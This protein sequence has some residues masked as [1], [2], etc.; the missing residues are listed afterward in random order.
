MND[1]ELTIRGF[2]GI[3]YCFVIKNPNSLIMYLSK[4]FIPTL[5][6]TP[7]D[8]EIASHRL[9]LRAGMIRRVGG[10]IFTFLPLGLRA[11]RHVE[12]IVREEMDRAGAIEVLMPG[13]QPRE[14]WEQ[15]GRY[16]AMRDVMFRMRDRQGH[17]LALGPTH[18]EV[19]T[20]LVA[21]EIHSYRQLPRTFYQVQ[22]KYRDEIRPRFGLMRAREF[23]MK[24]AYSFDTDWDAADGSYQAMYQAYERIFARCGL[25]VKVVEADSGAMGGQWSH[26]FMVPAE[27]GEDG[28]VECPQ[29]S[30]AAN[31]EKAE[32][33]R[34]AA[35][36]DGA[37]SAC[38]S[39]ENIAT[40]DTATI[41]AVSALLDIPAHRLIKTLIYS[42]DGRPVAVLTTGDREV[43]ELKLAHVLGCSEL[44]A[45]DAA[46][47]E[48]V[49]GAPVGY[50]GPIGLTIPI[51]ADLDLRGARDYVCGANQAGTHT[52]HIDM[53]RDVKDAAF[54][55]LTTAHDGDGCPR[56]QDG[57]LEARRGIEV[58]HVFKLGTKYTEAFDARYLTA[59]GEEKPLVMG[60]YGIGVTRALQAVIEQHHD[61]HGICWP[62]T[63]APYKVVLLPLNPDH[64]PTRETTERL[65]TEL[66]AAGWEPLIDDRDERPGVKFK[67]ADLVG[68]PVRV[69]ISERSLAAGGVEIKSRTADKAQTLPVAEALTKIGDLLS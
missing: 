35:P 51:H 41:E 56:C 37:S 5:R 3:V 39:P 54:A 69:V 45:A 1:R 63:V 47:V 34:R 53:A 7:Q 24:D 23:V 9:M 20:G 55:D 2:C 15:S 4:T 18:E 29:C 36:D 12:R 21:H 30:Y 11:L 32:R 68:Y 33:A 42:A 44:A 14:I 25:T 64:T 66:T 59:E 17:D 16:E 57:T 31:L 62:A 65:N 6:E 28:L 38:P 60:C 26:E 46:T 43:N 48:Q 61:A 19:I 40:P 52:L 8:A 13:L 22:T 49:T 50:A 27:S 67:D 10:G 58:G